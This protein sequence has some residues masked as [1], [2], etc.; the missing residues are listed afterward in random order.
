MRITNREAYGYLTDIRKNFYAVDL[1]DS[2]LRLLKVKMTTKLELMDCYLEEEESLY[3]LRLKEAYDNVF[4]TPQWREWYSKHI[5]L[6][7][8]KETLLGT[9]PVMD[10]YNE[11]KE[12]IP[13]TKKGKELLETLLLVNS[14]LH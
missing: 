3:F 14:F 11:C 1:G 6:E 12:T 13:H 5:E 4:C 10:Y 8:K 2:Y 9:L 7:T